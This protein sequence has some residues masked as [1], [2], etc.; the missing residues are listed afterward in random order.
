VATCTTPDILLV[1]EV[2]DVGDEAFKERAAKRMR[3]FI[4][5]SQIFCLASH[6]PETIAE[7]CNRVFVLNHGTLREIS[8]SQ[9][10][11]EGYGIESHA[12]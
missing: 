1:D 3:E 4:K 11:S 12:G 8:V 5:S 7:Y 2:F 10:K 9:L 6:S